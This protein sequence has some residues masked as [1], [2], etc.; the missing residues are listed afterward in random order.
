M[1]L[2]LV[3]IVGRQ[4]AGKTTLIVEI[5]AVLTCRGVHVGTIKHTGHLHELDT[6]GKDSHRQRIAGARPAAVLTPGLGAVYFPVGGALDPYGQL[7][8][9]F[10][11]CDLVLVEGHLDGPGPK[12]EVWRAGAQAP[13]AQGRQDI[14]AVVS[15]DRPG[16]ELPVWPLQD[17]PELATRVLELGRQGR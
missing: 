1:T 12:I 17:V 14:V 15:D 16:V 8:P 11:G 10:A 4:D 3:H 9:L 5:V 13:L 6:P 2:P 7:R